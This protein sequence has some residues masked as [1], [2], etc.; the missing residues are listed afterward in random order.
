MV[1]RL[2]ILYEDGAECEDGFGVSM[3][4]ISGGFKRGAIGRC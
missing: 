3:S 4:L 2:G 1:R